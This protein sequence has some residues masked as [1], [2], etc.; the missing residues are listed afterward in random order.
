MRPGS[1]CSMQVAGAMS[2]LYVVTNGAKIHKKGNIF[3]VVGPD[4]DELT[5]VG[6]NRLESVVMVQSAQATSQALGQMLSMG[7]QLAI[8][9][10]NG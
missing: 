9:T 3:R 4:G 7:I 10:H 2:I 8:F 5:E 1:D 6:A